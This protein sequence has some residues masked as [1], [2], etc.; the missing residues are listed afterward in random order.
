M[1]QM[2]KKPRFKFKNWW[3]QHEDFGDVVSKIWGIKVQGDIAVE[4]WQN[5]VRLFRRKVKGLE[6]QQSLSLER[7][8]ID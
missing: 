4:R 8:K 5:K 2:Q 7:K 3:I 6:C 1:G